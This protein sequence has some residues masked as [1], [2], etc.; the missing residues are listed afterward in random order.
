MIS[1]FFFKEY[2][3]LSKHVFFKTSCE[4]QPKMPETLVAQEKLSFTRRLIYSDM[5]FRKSLPS[6]PG[7][8]DKFTL[9]W[10]G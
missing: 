8:I 2:M 10:R 9:T 5:I 1:F 6:S 7:V 4:R 3:F